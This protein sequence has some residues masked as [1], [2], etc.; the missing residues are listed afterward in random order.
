MAD[1]SPVVENNADDDDHHQKNGH[2]SA[3]HYARVGLG[4]LFKVHHTSI[5]KPNVAV[6]SSEPITAHTSRYWAA[7]KVLFTVAHLHAVVS[8]ET[9]GANLSTAKAHPARLTPAPAITG[10]AEA[11]ILTG[12]LLSAVEAVRT[13][14]TGCCA[15]VALPPRH[16]EASPGHRVALAAILALALMRAVVAPPVFWTRFAAAQSH[17]A[18]AAMAFAGYVVTGTA[19]TVH[20]LGAHLGAVLAKGAR[21][22]RLAAVLASPASFAHTDARLGI[23]GGVVLAVACVLT[24]CTPLPTRALAFTRHTF[25]AGCANAFSSNVV[26]SK[27]VLPIALAL[28]LTVE[29]VFPVVALGVAQLSQVAR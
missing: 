6:F 15:V 21:W 7:D 20:A 12:A 18:R 1:P 10:S 16:A 17:V 25:D 8:E 22:A 23:T 11:S 13:I 28:F 26:T 9:L 2:T 19:I 4:L 29:S 14:G 27:R 24:R 5:Y 3:D